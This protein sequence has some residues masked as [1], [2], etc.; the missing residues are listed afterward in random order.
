MMSGHLIQGG[1]GIEPDC[2]Y[3]LHETGRFFQKPIFESDDVQFLESSQQLTWLQEKLR[4]GGLANGFIS[5]GKCLINEHAAEGQAL[6][7]DRK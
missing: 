3:S 5:L 4:P 2:S 1:L 7:D 6:E